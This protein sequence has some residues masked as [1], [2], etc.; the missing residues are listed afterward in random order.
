MFYYKS[1]LLQFLPVQRTLPIILLT[2]YCYCNLW[3]CCRWDYIMFLFIGTT[4]LPLFF[5]VLYSLNMISIVVEPYS[6]LN[7]VLAYGCHTSVRC[8]MSS[9]CF[10]KYITVLSYKL[11]YN[12][13]PLIHPL[14]EFY[15][16]LSLHLV[17]HCRLQIYVTNISIKIY[18]LQLILFC[19]SSDYIM[20]LL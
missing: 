20:F 19:C 2:N 18:S 12:V 17:L 16:I 9:R 3:F 14:V 10:S 8:S 7:W 15:S 4:A 11:N 1:L 5:N 13:E 6:K